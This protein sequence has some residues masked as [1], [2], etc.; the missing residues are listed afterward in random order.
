MK[1]LLNNDT[2]LRAGVNIGRSRSPMESVSFRRL[3]ISLGNGF[4]DEVELNASYI[5][6]YLV[7]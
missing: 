7:W 1:R 2:S 6:I 5:A 4:W 3:M